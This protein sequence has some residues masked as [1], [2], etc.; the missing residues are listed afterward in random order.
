MYCLALGNKKP[1]VL[2]FKRALTHLNF[3]KIKYKVYERRSFLKEEQIRILKT[4][5]EATNRM[6]LNMFAALGHKSGVGA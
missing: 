1:A 5:N 4:M 3:P 6:D 2:L